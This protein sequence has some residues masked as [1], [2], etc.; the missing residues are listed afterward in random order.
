MRPGGWGSER[1]ALFR[2]MSMATLVVGDGNFSF[3]LALAKKMESSEEKRIVSTSLETEKEVNECP[4]AKENV[5]DLRKLCVYILHGVDGTKLHSSHQLL[6]L[7]RQYSTIIFNFPHTGGKSNIKHNR[8]LLRDFF[9]SA[10]SVLSPRGR[11]CVTLCGGQGGTPVDSTHRGY[12][13]S[14]RIVEMAAEAGLILSQ[15]QPFN[16][17]TYPGYSPTGYRGRNKGFVLDGALEHVFTL[18]Q[19]DARSWES[20]ERVELYPCQCC[21]GGVDVSDLMTQRLWSETGLPHHSLFSLPWHPVTRLHRVIVRALQQLELGLWSSVSSELRDRVMVHRLPSLCCPSHRVAG[22]QWRVTEEDGGE[23]TSTAELVEETVQQTFTL[24]S[25]SHQL[26][27][28]LLTRTDSDTISS[29]TLHTV[30]C[31]VMRETATLP[32]HSLSLLQPLSHQLCGILHISGSNEALPTLKRPMI[33]VLSRVLSATDA[34]LHSSSVADEIDVSIAGEML[35]LVNFESYFHQSDLEHELTD[36]LPEPSHLVFTVHLDTLALAA[37][38]IPHPA[39]L[40]S[41][42]RRFVEQ[43]YGREDFDKITFHPFS[44]FP[45]SYTHDVSFWV[46]PKLMASFN[47]SEVTVKMGREVLRAVRAV[48]GLTALRVSLIDTYSSGER[49]SV[50]YRVEYSS[51]G[52][53]L[54]CTMAGELQLRVRERLA[55]GVEGLELR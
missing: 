44:L 36:R 34:E 42:D 33:Q 1:C 19:V 20:C 54:S 25:S 52:G 22:V 39:L 10:R 12:H 43:F 49:V 29:P 32:L 2:A 4:M 51:P 55:R 38:A 11:V 9:V 40:W 6:A 18:P 27:P 21:C 16:V 8:R 45:P 47:E 23:S 7:D 53:A 26:V 46:P 24:Q 30:S 41:Q 48:A 14:W 5:N 31:P 28:S 15:V 3:S 35:L 13:N 17:S 37:Y 50:C